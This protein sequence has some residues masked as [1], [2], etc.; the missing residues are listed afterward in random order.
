MKTVS[1]VT[2]FTAASNLM[3]YV[4]FTNL[5]ENKDSTIL[6]GVDKALLSMSTKGN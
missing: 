3:D 2:G 6:L 1:T 4:Y 5:V